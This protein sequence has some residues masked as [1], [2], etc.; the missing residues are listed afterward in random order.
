MTA[1]TSCRASSYVLLTLILR[2]EALKS[3]PMSTSILRVRR[4]SCSVI[5]G[6]LLY[7]PDDCGNELSNSEGGPPGADIL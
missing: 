2:S 7:P 4:P 5:T 3:L 1:M 6:P